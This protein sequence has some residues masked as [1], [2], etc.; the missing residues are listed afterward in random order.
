MKR[1]RE[2]AGHGVHDA[3]III[4]DARPVTKHPRHVPSS[5]SASTSSLL[6]LFDTHLHDDL[7]VEIAQRLI[8]PRDYWALARVS[9]RTWWRLGTDRNLRRHMVLTYWTSWRFLTRIL[10]C[11]NNVRQLNGTWQ[12]EPLASRLLHTQRLYPGLPHIKAIGNELLHAI[13]RR[14][15]PVRALHL[16]RQ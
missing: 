1:A 16:K 8:D 4:G 10:Q 5:S 14:S 6:S 13:D 9:Q 15:P 2:T 7:L 12:P 3:D 11:P